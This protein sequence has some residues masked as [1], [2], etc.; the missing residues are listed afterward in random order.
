MRFS[1]IYKEKSLFSDQPIKD[2]EVEAPPLKRRRVQFTDPPVSDQVVIPRCPSG[3][4]TRQKLQ[5]SR[6]NKDMFLSSV[7]KDLSATVIDTKPESDNNR[8]VNMIIYFYFQ[9]TKG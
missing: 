2:P 6:F 8:L 4:A 7:A 3:K 5:E 9:K 1:Q